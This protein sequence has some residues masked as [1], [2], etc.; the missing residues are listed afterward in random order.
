[1]QSFCLRCVCSSASGRNCGTA[2]TSCGGNN[3]HPASASNPARHSFDHLCPIETANA[4][5]GGSGLLYE[6]L[7]GQA[8]CA[9]LFFAQAAG[10]SILSQYKFLRS[11][12]LPGSGGSPAD[13]RFLRGQSHQRRGR[14]GG[15]KYEFDVWLERRR[16]TALKIVIKVGGA[17]LEDEAALIK[18]ARA[19]VEMARDGH[20][21]AVVHGGGTALTRTLKLLGKQSEFIHGLRITDAETRDV[22]LMVLAG[23]VN[24]KVVAAI[25]KAGLAAVGFCGGVGMTFR[26][27]K[28]PTNGHDLWFVG[29]IWCVEAPRFRANL[30]G[31]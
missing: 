8:I 10:D 19:A 5:R 6:F 11:R 21:V 29:A 12:L 3:V 24:K 13:H 25:V 9:R 16:G 15:S 4:S 26:P 22:A 17:A 18:C 14:P 27:L 30:P 28:E 20:K 31:R 1:R 7:Q 2:A 23:M